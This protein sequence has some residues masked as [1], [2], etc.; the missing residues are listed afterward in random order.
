MTAPIK[1]AALLVLTSLAGSSLEAQHRVDVE[2]FVKLESVLQ[3]ALATAS[4]FVVTIET[5]GG[6]RRVLTGGPT[7]DGQGQPRPGQPG[8]QAPRT[9]MPLKKPGFQQ[10]Q[11][12]SSGIIIGADGWI[13]VSRFSLNYD[14]TTI[15]VTIPG[16]ETHH[17][18]RRG[19]DTSRGLALLKIDAED[20]PVAEFVSPEDVRVGQWAF[21]LG[22]T[23]GAQ[24]PTVHIGI[25]SARHR[26]F[27]RALQI[28]AYTSPA[29]YGGAVVDIHGRVL[30]MA[31]PLSPAGRDAGVEWYDSGIGFATTIADI[32]ELIERMKQGETLHRGWLG[33]SLEPSH[34]GPGAKL[35]GTPKDGVAAQADLR[36]GDIVLE[37]DGIAVKNGFHLQMLVS[38]RMGGDAVG[39]KV[40]KKREKEPVSLTVLLA[41]A[42][43]EEREQGGNEVPASFSLPE[44][45][46]GR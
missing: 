24:D 36:K 33:V 45:E 11:G 26:Q 38:S 15:L 9:R 44:K 27:G 6:A 2:E 22:R 37:I 5:F 29:N 34:L 18:E 35:S 1:L 10:T 20:L 40:K 3:A 41:E 28:D 19:E 30:G 12:R 42:P 7:I 14:P 13:L 31:V 17:A 32:P 43:S 4:P 21:A 39:M 16:G 8:G 46:D 23:F 25:V